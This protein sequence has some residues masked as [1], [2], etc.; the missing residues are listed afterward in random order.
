[1]PLQQV[2][3]DGEEGLTNHLTKTGTIEHGVASTLRENDSG[4]TYGNGKPHD[5]LV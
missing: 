1:M 4:E 3:E 2:H 5:Y